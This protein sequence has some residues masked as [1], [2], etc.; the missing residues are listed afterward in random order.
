MY[1][2]A[3]RGEKPVFY[4]V[5]WFFRYKGQQKRSSGKKQTNASIILGFDFFFSRR[6][7]G[8]FDSFSIQGYKLQTSRYPICPLRNLTGSCFCPRL[9]GF[10][11]FV[12]IVSYR[13]V[14]CCVSSV[15]RRGDHLRRKCTSWWTLRAWSAWMRH[16]QIRPSSIR[17]RYGW[18]NW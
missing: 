6:Q 17:S 18:M 7:D 16:L 8:S 14:S 4:F 10:S 15:G 9:L 3:G 2:S 13:I 12:R 5:N 1:V 11:V